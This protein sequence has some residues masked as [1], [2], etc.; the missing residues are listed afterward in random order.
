MRSRGLKAVVLSSALV[1]IGVVAAG[2]VA[3]REIEPPAPARAHS[4]AM[5]TIVDELDRRPPRPDASSPNIVLIIGCTVRRDQTTVYAAEMDTTP[6]LASLATRG[7]LADDLIAAAPWTKPASTAI[8]T[9]RHAVGVGLIEPGIGRNERVLSPSVHTIAEQL[10]EVGW[11]TAGFT[12]NPN[13][14]QVFGFS[15]GFDRYRQLEQLWSE[16]S[17]KIHGLDAVAEVLDLARAARK[18]AGRR[19]LYLQ[20]ALVDAHAPFPVIEGSDDLLARYRLGLTGLDSTISSIHAGLTELGLTQDNTIFVVVSDHGEGLLMPEHH[21]RSHGRFLFPST[22]EALWL[23][24]GPSVPSGGRLAGVT[25]QIDVAPTVMGL[26]GLPMRDAEGRD[27]SE[28]VRAGGAAPPGLAFTDT[29]FQAED[30]VGFYDLGHACIMAHSGIATCFDRRADPGFY[31]PKAEAAASD[32][33]RAWR[34][35]QAR[36]ATALT[37]ALPRSLSAGEAEFLEALGYHATDT[38]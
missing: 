29:W 18:A 24:T 21:G 19:P 12:A 13:L 30:K 37:Q 36:S 28:A 8:L 23:I 16:R 27:L 7:V 10:R 26:A 6:F 9:G 31:H 5:V 32:V 33:L 3:M 38:E 34:A 35:R 2:V 4:A 22:V 20:V 15:R 1:G 17:V 14:N 11:Y 25:S